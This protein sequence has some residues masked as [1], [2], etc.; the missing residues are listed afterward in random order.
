MSTGT[1]HYGVA[2]EKMVQFAVSQRYNGYG[3]YSEYA[4]AWCAD[5]AT[6]CAQKYALTYNDNPVQKTPSC[7]RL[8][9]HFCKN[10]NFYISSYSY[11]HLK[12]DNSVDIRG[13][14]II[15]GKNF[16]PKRGD[17]VFFD[18]PNSYHVGIVTKAQPSG[19]NLMKIFTVEGNTTGNCVDY[20]EYTFNMRT[21]II[22]NNNDNPSSDLSYVVGFGRI[23]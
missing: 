20:R 10:N 13:A 6:Y 1:Y 2:I 15:T 8:M 5:F 21:G 7:F 9:E 3:L 11:N 19:N 18:F 23:R 14:I 12:N 16:T 17:F 22:G 4:D